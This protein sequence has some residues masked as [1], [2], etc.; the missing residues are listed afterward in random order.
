[1]HWYGVSIE[2]QHVPF[3]GGGH[4]AQRSAAV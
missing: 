1:M 3:Q 2:R 4:I